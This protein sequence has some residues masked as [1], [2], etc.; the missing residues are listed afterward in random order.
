MSN[1]LGER[2][3]SNGAK[4]LAQHKY[5]EAIAFYK[6][7]IE[8]DPTLMSNYWYLRLALLLQE[9]ESEAMAIRLDALKPNGIFTISFRAVIILIKIIITTTQNDAKFSVKDMVVIST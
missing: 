7:S 9:Q 3:S 8:S 2:Y 1:N 5:S 4:Y 6:K